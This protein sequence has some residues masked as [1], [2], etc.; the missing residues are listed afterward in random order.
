M[1]PV[2]KMVN[3]Q[4]WA[5]TAAQMGFAED[6]L[7]ATERTMMY[8][9]GVLSGV[10]DK[11]VTLE[12]K[13]RGQEGVVLSSIQAI[14]VFQGHGGRAMRFLCGLADRHKIVLKLHVQ[15]FG[16]DIGSPLYHEHSLSRWYMRRGF[17]TVG[18]GYYMAR[19]P[20]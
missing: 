14:P 8:E 6:F 3:D 12:C 1:D 10:F 7:R 16:H 11:H 17:V 2:K 19:Q 20:V 18:A 9:P 5:W 13:P 15:P 4:E